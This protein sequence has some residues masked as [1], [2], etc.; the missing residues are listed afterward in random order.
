MRK[1]AIPLARHAFSSPWRCCSASQDSLVL[2]SSI[3]IEKRGDR[4]EAFAHHGFSVLESDVVTQAVGRMLGVS[5]CRCDYGSWRQN[6]MKKSC[7]AHPADISSYLINSNNTPD[8]LR[9]DPRGLDDLAPFEG[10]GGLEN[11]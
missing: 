6:M 1:P 11:T 10:F 9:H 8:L 5:C 3:L 7:C 4:G 2:T